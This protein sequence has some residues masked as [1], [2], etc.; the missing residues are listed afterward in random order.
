MLPDE[1]AELLENAVAERGKP[2]EAFA[3]GRAE[4]PVEVLHNWA[5]QLKTFGLDAE[6]NGAWGIAGVFGREWVLKP[7]CPVWCDPFSLQYR[8]KK[9]DN[10]EWPV[11]LHTCMKSD[12]RGSGNR[13]GTPRCLGES[14]PMR[15]DNHKP[16]SPHCAD[17]LGPSLCHAG[18]GFFCW[19]ASL[20][21][22]A[23]FLFR[24]TI[25]VPARRPSGNLAP[26]KVPPG[27]PHPRRNRR[28][29]MDSILNDGTPAALAGLHWPDAHW[30]E[31]ALL[32]TCVAVPEDIAPRLIYADWLQDHDYDAVADFIRIQCGFH[33]AEKIDP[34]RRNASAW[35]AEVF[36][37]SRFKTKHRLFCELS[38][39]RDECHE[40]LVKK[41]KDSYL[42]TFVRGLPTKAT[43]DISVLDELIRTG[44]EE[45]LLCL[46]TELHVTWKPASVKGWYG[47]FGNMAILYGP[48]KRVPEVKERLAASPFAGPLT[49]L[50]RAGI[51]RPADRQA[52]VHS[53]LKAASY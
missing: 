48:A 45:Q 2:D 33:P 20:F 46:L 17:F 21:T 9:L 14:S 32:E 13:V 24:A 47:V 31:L 44:R 15:W 18:D 28:C 25:R 51:R 53:E 16:T 8:M 5:H 52:P 11:N 49:N 34:T 43:I 29:V 37:R 22:E 7:N 6:H 30:E 10:R 42:R 50:A 35:A 38:A 26:A 40:V 4:A 3:V 19:R 27:S 23:D 1:A 36:W 39:G 41:D 12:P